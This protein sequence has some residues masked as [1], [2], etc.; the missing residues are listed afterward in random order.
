[1]LIP[2]VIIASAVVAFAWIKVR[3][4]RRSEPLPVR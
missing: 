1:M 3:H 2:I 4:K